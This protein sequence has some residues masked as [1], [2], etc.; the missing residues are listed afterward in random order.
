MWEPAWLLG[1]RTTHGAE[2]TEMF[3]SQSW[4]PEVCELVPAGPR[5]LCGTDG[6]SLAGHPQPAMALTPPAPRQHR[7]AQRV[8]ELVVQGR[9]RRAASLRKQDARPAVSEIGAG[10]LEPAAASALCQLSGLFWAGTALGISGNG[11]L[12]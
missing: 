10:P 11:F 6:R 8:L 3:S 7:Q 2:T 1:H 4:R 9:C 5:G 12:H